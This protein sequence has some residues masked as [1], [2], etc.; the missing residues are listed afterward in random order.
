MKHNLI[1]EKH[2]KVCWVLKY[3]EYFLVFVST[4]SRCATISA[5]ASWV[6]FPVVIASSA[7]GLINCALQ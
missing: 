1:S 6:G 2:E 7:I 3:L 5:F 4:V